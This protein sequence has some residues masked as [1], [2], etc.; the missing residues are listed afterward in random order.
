MKI[1]K[2]NVFI[3]IVLMFFA[4]MS[5]C[6]AYYATKIDKQITITTSSYEDLIF[7][8]DKEVYGNNVPINLT[9]SNPNP[10]D[11][12]YTFNLPNNVT[13]QVD[14]ANVTSY[15]VNANSAKTN[16]IVVS[17][18][19]G[20][21]L[22]ITIKMTAPYSKN[23]TK[24]IALDV[25][26][27][28]GS[29]TSTNNQASSQ[30]ATLTCSDE[31]GVASYYWGTS[32]NP[33]SGDYTSITSTTNLST[34]ATV[35]AAG[36]YY[37]ICKDTAGNTSSINKTFY[38][39]TLTMTN[40]S[41][42]PA[43]IVTLSGNSFVLPT[44]TVSTGYTARGAWYTSNAYSTSVGNYGASYKPTASTTLYSTAPANTYAIGYSYNGG[45]K[46]TN[47]PA[48]GTYDS[49]VT[50]DNPNRSG[51]TF[52]GWTASGLD[53]ATAVYGT[54]TSPTTTWNGT[55]KVTSKYFKNLRSTSGTV[56]LTA[57][58]E[59]TAT[60]YYWDK[61]NSKIAT[62]TATC[63][64]TTSC[65]VTIPTAVTGSTSQYGST[66]IG[67]ATSLSSMTTTVG[68]TSTTITISANTTYYGVYRD[69]V[70]IY[71]PMSTSAVTY[72]TWYR[73]AYFTSSSAMATR[74]STS[75]TG[76]SN[77]TTVSGITGT[78]KGLATSANSTSTIAIS[79]AATRT[80]TTYYAVSTSNISAT[81]YYWD[82]TNN[83]ITSTNG[84][85][86]R[87]NY[88][89]NA[90][91]ASTSSGTITAPV[92]ITSLTSQYGA[93]GIGWATS[94][95]SMNTTSPTTANTT[96]Y[97][98]YRDNVTIYYPTSTSA[99][100]YTTW[101]RNA[102]FTSA[103]AMATRLSTS[104]T[105]TSNATTVSG[106]TGTY[107]G[108]ATSANSTSTIAISSAA[109]R[110]E[111]TYYA[112]STSNISATFYYWDTTNSKITSKTA[113]GTRTN[114][115]L[116]TSTATTSSGTIT[117]PV[118]ITS[119]TSQYG[120]T[121]IGWATGTSSMSTTSPTTASTTYYAVYRKNVTL[122]YPTNAT[123]VA[124]T[125]WYRNA[126]FTSA[127]TMNTVLSSSSTGTSNA[128]ITGT[129][130]G[131]ATA[132]NT[133]STV[134]VSE[135]ATATNT[136]FYAVSASSVSATFYYWDTTNSKIT[137]KSA[138]GDIIYYC[139]SATAAATIGGSITPPV[140]IT[141]LT[142]QYGVTGIGWAT[143]TGTMSTTSP[144][145]ASTTYYAVYRKNVTIY[146]PTSSA[147]SSTTA[148]RNAFF[149]STSAMNTVLSTSSTGTS[150]FTTIS[151]IVGTF[152]GLAASVN[153]TSYSTVALSATLSNTA[154]YAVSTSNISATFY[155]QSSSTLGT[156][157]V[158]STSKSG[159]RTNYCKTT[160]TLGTSNGSIAI[161]GEVIGSVGKYNSSYVGVAT[162][163]GTMSSSSSAT[164]ANTT[165][166]AV[167]RK[168]VTN[169]YYNSSYTSRTIYRN[170]WLT[171][172]SSTSCATPVL[173]TSAT[174]RTNYSTAS[175]PGSSAWTGLATSKTTTVGYS[176]VSAAAQS[177]A[178]ILYSIYQFNVTY[179]KGANVSAIGA[180]SGSCKVT[181]SNTSCSVTLPTITANSGYTLVG[182]STTNGATSGTSA[183]SSYT[184][185]SNSTT[186][187]G[188]AVD[189]V[190]PVCTFGNWSS[191][192]I[193]KDQT[194][195]INL[196]CTDS[197]SGVSTS[198]L[199]SSSFTVSNANIIS[200]SSITSSGN[201]ASRVFTITVQGESTAGNA[202]ISLISGKVVDVAGNGNVAKTSNS[203]SNKGNVNADTLYYVLESEATS[204]SGLAKTYTGAHQD[205]YAGTGTKNIY[206]YNATS[207]ANATTILDKNNVIFAGFCWQMLRTTD[208]GGVKII[209]NGE[210]EDGKCL[211]T[212]STHVGFDMEQSSGERL[213]LSN[214]YYY[215]TSYTY[216]GSTFSLAGTKISATW[217]DS[218]YQNLIGMYTC[219][220]SSS[221]GTC[222]T[223]YYVKSYQN[224]TDA[225]CLP[226]NFTEVHY[227]VIGSIHFN[228]LANSPSFAGY[229]YNYY[230][231]NN[232][233]YPNLQTN[234][235]YASSFTYSNG[236]YYLSGEQQ[237]IPDWAS[238]YNKT[239]NTH[240]TCWN[241]SGECETISY[242]HFAY[243]Q[244]AYYINLTGGKS[245]SDALVEMLSADNVNT[246]NSTI[247]TVIDNWYKQNMLSYTSYLE[248]TIFC[249]DR[250]IRELGGWNPNGGSTFSVLRF[251]EYS[252]GSDLSCTNETD[253]FSVSNPK[254]QLTYP[255]GLASSPEMNLLGNDTLRKTGQKYLLASPISFDIGEMT[256]NA[257]NESGAIKNNYY[258]SGVRP[259]VS[260]AP[261]TKYIAGGDGSMENP[262]VVNTN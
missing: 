89:V 90:T 128:V 155:Y 48:S 135:A 137:S 94:T 122:Y 92:T 72:T 15:K 85:G 172:T 144:T 200:I 74:L 190:A 202:T 71:Y 212:R 9:V 10:Y 240:Y 161:P 3:I 156:C 134:S 173:S 110:T 70:T 178:T 163:S 32:S 217:S 162:S 188:N 257:V 185:S 73:N 46:G 227:S 81:F 143:S 29:I 241:T 231:K 262:Y 98:V 64:G 51:Y 248:D 203:L 95:S 121:G 164:T 49:L 224:S 196:T 14:G 35:N 238:D 19:S 158:T 244:T 189:N 45:S 104:S 42:S 30:T 221:T 106:I 187:Y 123:T 250:S 206:Y 258:N 76:T 65:S 194:A 149:T 66:Y 256:W 192:A 209:Y 18:V 97:G 7:E 213:P 82:S 171:G 5:N 145:T 60:F 4:C 197:A 43:T 116:N 183:G 88:C 58:W 218:T 245:V 101:Y 119:L 225:L 169:Y 118:T 230:E 111:T 117:A 154:F 27:P 105:G 75:S 243:F 233:I 113:S 16:V 17:G 254:A 77:A 11:I 226:L 140:T 24:T 100:T 234:Y 159:T 139:A 148:Y 96:Y 34:T 198:S 207:N 69:N 220:S 131:L 222:S 249:N 36:T 260:L 68:K 205:S 87:T 44:P 165:Y 168:N 246:T 167:Y 8:F 146:Y 235:L 108:L 12:T 215:G 125:T 37:L 237:T 22:G 120:A 223:L 216:D 251:K 147:V 247:K 232:Q 50:I 112:V 239:S 138:S 141:N 151:G 52:K 86:T 109:T 182:W 6:L 1:K 115:C 193:A 59:Y 133:T 184:L 47:A 26:A 219:L 2:V 259:S 236:K 83:K 152:K 54:T 33:L 170:E 204:G 28:V 253:K 67:L 181:T 63:I 93:N 126:Y 114:Y 80:E 91:T 175:G 127:S 124:Y 153:T 255:V 180:T 228:A 150:D 132:V 210:A 211:N 56:T 242:I 57:N 53:T 177:N 176:S 107:K 199:T 62:T 166:Y 174:G 214:Y 25:E 179:S 129:F 103:S 61:T 160:S 261:G 23:Y 13:Y 84:S 157:S 79:S 99:V 208:T 201:S 191:S 21:T 102:Y 186:L 252:V 41:V 229:M 40:G 20:S 31:V 136:V 78:Y 195:T 130:E 55:T 38:K 39:T 142:S